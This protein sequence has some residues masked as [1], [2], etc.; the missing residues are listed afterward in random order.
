MKSPSEITASLKRDCREPPSEL[1]KTLNVKREG[2]EIKH[3]KEYIILRYEMYRIKKT[4]LVCFN[5]FMGIYGSEKQFWR[6]KK[7]KTNIFRVCQGW[8][9]LLTTQT[10]NKQTKQKN[11]NKINAELGVHC[12]ASW[13][14]CEAFR[15]IYISA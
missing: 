3:W 7:L 8:P 9:Y 6:T 15:I 12:H 11:T 13:N 4:F 5:W 14:V 1:L 2:G 10:N